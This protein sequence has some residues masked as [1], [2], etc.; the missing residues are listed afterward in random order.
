MLIDIYLTCKYEM[1]IDIYDLIVTL[2]GLRAHLPIFTGKNSNHF[3]FLWRPPQRVQC[4][5]LHNH[6]KNFCKIH[7]DRK[8]QD[9]YVYSQQLPVQFTFLLDFLLKRGLKC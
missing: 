1:L 4:Y 5:I 9:R 7:L 3:Y 8:S 6:S 2:N